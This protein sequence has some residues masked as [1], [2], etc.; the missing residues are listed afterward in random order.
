MILEKKRRIEFGDFQ[1]PDTLAVHLCEHLYRL[2][3]RPDTIIEPTCGVGAF[4]LAAAHTFTDAR[5]V[6][7]FEVNETYLGMLRARLVND[8]VAARVQIEHADF[9]ATDWE[10]KTNAMNG[11]LLVVGNFPWVTNATQGTIGGKNLPVKSNC[12]GFSGFDAISGK[13]NF[14]ISEWML[15]DVLRWLSVR[16]GDVA[17][18]IK[19]SVARKVLAHAERRRYPVMDAAIIEIDAKKHFGASVNACLLVIQLDIGVSASYDYTV[20]KSLEDRQGRRVGHRYGLTVS[21]LDTFHACASLVGQSPQKWRSGIKH[22]A[23][24]VMELTRCASS[25]ENGFGESVELEDLYLFPLL[26]GSDIGSNKEWREKFVLVTQRTV[27]ED[28]SPIQSHAPRTWAYLQDHA[29]QLDARRSRIYSKNPRFSVFGV[30]DYAFKPWRIAIC[31][32]YKALKFRLVPPMDG[33]PVM[34]DDTVYYLSF[35]TE[36]DACQTLAIIESHNATDLLLS[37]IFWD[38]KRPIK[39][40]ILNVLD[41]SQLQEEKSAIAVTE[42]NRSSLPMT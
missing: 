22:D 16:G 1:T 8:P 12:L 28:T 32:L 11:R 19:T 4:V 24:A 29:D 21:D 9:F 40:S 34:F 2:G 15:L 23:S 5:K 35:D 14:D 10:A 13:A 39:T 26:K 37:L 30:G 3:L 17:M 25:Y 31:G 27:G 36:D 18:L 42:K 6:F 33:R 38:E 7:G 41:W 20:F